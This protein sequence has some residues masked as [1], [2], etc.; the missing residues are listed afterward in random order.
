MIQ[1]IQSIYLAIATVLQGLLF[2]FPFASAEK[3]TEGAFIDGELDLYDN[4]GLLTL[5]II[6]I[7]V[8]AFC[9]FLYNNRPLQMKISMAG[10]LLSIAQLAVAA[11]FA[12][13][14]GVSTAIGIG[15]FLPI[16][17]V[18]LYFL[19]YRGIKSDEDLVKSSNRLR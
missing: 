3:T 17:T 9:I 12:F 8:A 19:A 6:G 1:R 10:I 11:Y 13:G 16:L 2:A 15:F 4:G 18:I 7:L 5:S 14:T